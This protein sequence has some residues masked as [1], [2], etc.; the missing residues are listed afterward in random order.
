MTTKIINLY[1]FRNIPKYKSFFVFKTFQLN[2]NINLTS[3]IKTS[4]LTS[5]IYHGSYLGVSSLSFS[6]NLLD[7]S[8]VHW[9]QSSTF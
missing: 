1:I 3:T 5:L 7:Y 8:S 9:L 4:T 2:Y 6:S